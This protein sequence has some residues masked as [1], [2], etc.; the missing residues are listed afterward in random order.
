M[1]KVGIIIACIILSAII[2]LG[3]FETMS[4]YH[5]GNIPTKIVILRMV[6]VFCSLSIV[7]NI[8]AFQIRKKGK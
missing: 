8:I 4:W 2:T 5:V 1:K 3:L 7:T 6:T